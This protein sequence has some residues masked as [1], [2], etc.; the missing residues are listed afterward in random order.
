MEIRT[1]DL[2]PKAVATQI[3][4]LTMIGQKTTQRRSFI[5]TLKDFTV[6][7]DTSSVFR[8]Y[9]SA[10]FLVASD[11]GRGILKAS[12]TGPSSFFK[13]SGPKKLPN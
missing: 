1:F 11:R 7:S 4:F 5:Q 12:W 13:R 3:S 10:T 8:N 9:T 2:L 6:T